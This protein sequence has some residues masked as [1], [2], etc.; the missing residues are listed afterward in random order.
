MYVFVCDSPNPLHLRPLHGLGLLDDLE[1]LVMFVR[2]D[3]LG[4]LPLVHVRSLDGPAR[5]EPGRTQSQKLRPFCENT[6]FKIK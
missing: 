5:L 4:L 3:G 6:I 2:R 1:N